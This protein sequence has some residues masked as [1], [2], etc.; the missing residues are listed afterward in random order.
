MP[1][2]VKVTISVDAELL[3]DLGQVSRELHQPRSR[4]VEE[5]LLLWRRQQLERALRD[6]YEAMAEED[7]AT[8]ERNLR[9]GWEAIE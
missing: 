8:V 7:R 2:K 3:R 4:I 9:A 1:A 5:A 6:G